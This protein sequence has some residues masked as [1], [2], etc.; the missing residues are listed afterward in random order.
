MMKAI[1][2]L[3]TTAV[4]SFIFSNAIAIGMQGTSDVKK[5]IDQTIEHLE[6]AI[7]AFDKGEDQKVVAERLMEAKQVQK[8]ISS[9]NATL[10]MIKS[11]A[12]QK[13]G[14][15][16]SSFNDSDLIGGGAAM[17]EALANFKELKK[18]YNAAY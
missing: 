1:K 8:S 18:K 16:R 13:L 5:S 6:K 9:S 12:T 14:Q 15:A 2:I 3:L 4:L 17:K 10:S 7:A 11:K